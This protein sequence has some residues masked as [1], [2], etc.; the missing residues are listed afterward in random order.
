MDELIGYILLGLVS[1]RFITKLGKSLPVLELMLLL[2]VLQWYIGPLNSYSADVARNKYS[3]YVSSE[4]YFSY[5]TPALVVFILVI[6]QAKPLE[7]SIGNDQLTSSNKL[8]KYIVIVG[9]LVGVVRPFVPPSLLFVFFILDGLKYVGVS[10]L[11]F[12]SERKDK[13][14]FWFVVGLL[15][16]Q[17]FSSG[18][19]HGLL[20]WGLFL[21]MYWCLRFKPTMIFK[22]SI[23]M[24]GIFLS[25]G[26]QLIKSD[27][28]AIIW[29][30]GFEG[31]KFGLAMDIL[32]GNLSETNFED[33]SDKEELNA[34]LNQGWIISAI[35]YHTPQNEPFARGSTINEAISAS[36]LPR[37]L[38][39]NK[40]KAGG[41]DNFMRYT[42]L[43]LGETTSMGL[44]IV[45]E[46]YANF[47]VDGG[48]L[49]MGIWALFLIWYWNRLLHFIRKNKVLVF[50]IPVIFLQVVKAETELVV[51]LNHLVKSTILVAVLFW[52][53]R[54]FLK[55][56]I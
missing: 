13:Y 19:F 51:V 27:F 38:A 43:L 3:M 54:K 17:A 23:I 53:A 46:A 31:N 49:F 24:A 39:P 40:K 55:W 5:I 41:R 50:F 8:S 20:L 37:F 7:F 36:L 9:L 47:G 18:M 2:A 35:M 16:F 34:R 45:G 48:I 30:G 56:D 21:F 26:I 4:I 14:W 10:M 6:F 1:Y 32:Q 52:G 11:L 42:G 44:S 33:D 22:V 28:R 15:V 12:S 25:I 29:K